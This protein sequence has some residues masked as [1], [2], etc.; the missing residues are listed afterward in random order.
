MDGVWVGRKLTSASAAL[1]ERF[2]DSLLQAGPGASVVGEIAP[3]LL[4]EM[5]LSLV[6]QETDWRRPFAR[7]RGLFRLPM[8]VDEAELVRAFNVLASLA[9]HFVTSLPGSTPEADRFT[10]DSLRHA[11]RVTLALRRELMAGTRRPATERQ[12][13]G[14]VLLVYSPEKSAVRGVG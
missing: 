5:G 7:T 2:V 11:A 6:R 9:S 1:T 14:I 8:S 4:A 13:G 3:Q 12:F 10:R